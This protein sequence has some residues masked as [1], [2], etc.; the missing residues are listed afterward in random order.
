MKRILDCGRLRYDYSG[1]YLKTKVTW[2]LGF[3]MCT[4]SVVYAIVACFSSCHNDPKSKQFQFGFLYSLG[5]ALV[6]LGLGIGMLVC[7]Y[8]DVP[9]SFV[10]FWW[11]LTVLGCCVGIIMAAL[12][13]GIGW[14]VWTS[15][16]GFVG[17]SFD[18]FLPLLTFF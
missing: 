10:A 15:C 5:S 12:P 1:Q 9:Y 18:V 2:R 6:T 4:C 14:F 16:F 7:H 3:A 8:R 11:L 17:S 13:L